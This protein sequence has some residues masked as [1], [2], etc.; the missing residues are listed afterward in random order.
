MVFCCCLVSQVVSDSS[1]PHGLWPP[2]L[3]CPSPSPGVC[4]SSR[5]VNQHCHSTV[6]FSVTLFSFCLQS[7]PTSGSFSVSH[8]FASGS[9]SIEASASVLP[10]SIQGWFPLTLTGLISLLS[11]GLSRVFSSTTVQKHQFLSALLSLLSRSLRVLLNINLYSGECD[12]K[13]LVPC[14]LFLFD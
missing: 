1:R 9:Q 14:F 4:P 6:S 2:R 8:L 3:L 13:T 10:K 7:F 12:R 11:K 5:P